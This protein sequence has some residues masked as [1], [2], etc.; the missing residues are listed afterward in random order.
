MLL[1]AGGAVAALAFLVT[2]VGWSRQRQLR[3]LRA[4]LSRVVEHE[5]VP[6]LAADAEGRLIHANAAARDRYAPG[7]D[8]T[9][10]SVVS[11]IV[12]AAR[13][14]S[15]IACGRAPRKTGCCQRG[16][17]AAPRLPAHRG[18]LARGRLLPL[19]AGGSRGSAFRGGRR[20]NHLPADV[21]RDAR[22][23]DPDE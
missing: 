14:A 15:S 19:A 10:L 12:A 3:V 20:G 8:R 9:L 1:F 17:D 18:S 2:I 7:T 11:D 4:V 22:R 23:Y 5:T 6:C 21:H 16:R 13:S